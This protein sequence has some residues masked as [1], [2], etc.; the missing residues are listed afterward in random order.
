MVRDACVTLRARAA[1]SIIRDGATERADNELKRFDRGL[2]GDEDREA[3][4]ES[5]ELVLCGVLFAQRNCLLAR[6]EGL[7]L[8]ARRRVRSWV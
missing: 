7:V 8:L 3:I 6:G 1:F 2:A 4:E 5:G